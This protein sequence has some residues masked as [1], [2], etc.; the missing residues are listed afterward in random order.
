MTPRSG[1]RQSDS[2]CWIVYGLLENRD[3]DHDLRFI[4][5]SERPQEIADAHP[6]YEACMAFPEG[7][8]DQLTPGMKMLTGISAATEMWM[9]GGRWP[10]AAE[11][12]GR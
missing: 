4:G 9:V 7:A 3:T 6:E 5:I 1:L 11:R 12:A 10:N 2:Q 8:A